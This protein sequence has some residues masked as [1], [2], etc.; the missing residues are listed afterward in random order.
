MTKD[1]LI[2]FPCLFPVKII[3]LHSPTFIEEIKQITIK[4]F[5]DFVEENLVHKPSQK[6][7]YLAITVTVFAQNKELLDAF[8]HEITK[9]AQVKMVL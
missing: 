9:H 3:G 5:P 6:N 1:T 7:N 2:D 8:Y 4:H